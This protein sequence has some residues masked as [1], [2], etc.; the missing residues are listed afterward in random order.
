MNMDITP[1]TIIIEFVG[2]FIAFEIYMAIHQ[3]LYKNKKKKD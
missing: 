1:L 2:G 3:A